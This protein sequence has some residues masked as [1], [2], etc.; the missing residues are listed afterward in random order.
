MKEGLE[1]KIPG[2]PVAGRKTE[3]AHIR[4]LDPSQV[5]VNNL[6][7]GGKPMLACSNNLFGEQSII[8]I[9]INGQIKYKKK[10]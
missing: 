8:R 7:R 2:T 5:E 10:S 6:C 3:K 9:R 1:E 4:Q